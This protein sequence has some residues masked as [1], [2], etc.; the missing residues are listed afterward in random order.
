MSKQIDEEFVKSKGWYKVKGFYID[1]EAMRDLPD[2]WDKCYF[3]KEDFVDFVFKADFWQHNDIENVYEDIDSLIE[4]EYE[5]YLNE[6][7]YLDTDKIKK[8]FEELK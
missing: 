8:E 2:S 1:L 4:T 6:D 3:S 7:G 5:E